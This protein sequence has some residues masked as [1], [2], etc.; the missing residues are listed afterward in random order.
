MAETQ[1]EVEL[2]IPQYLEIL[3]RRRWIIL[4]LASLFFCAAAAYA[5]LLPPVFRATTVL[6]IEKETG[7]AVQNQNIGEWQDDASI[8]TQFQ[9]IVSAT[10]LSRIYDD[11]KLS[12]SK[13]FS[14]GLDSLKNAVKVESVAGTRLC[15]INVDSTDPQLAMK[16]SNALAQNFVDENLN[17]KLSM[18]KDVLDALQMRMRGEDA[19]RVTMSLPSVVNNPLIQGIKGQINTL[20]AQL[21]EQRMKYTNSHPVIISLRSRLAQMQRELDREV[22]NIVQSVKTELSGQLRAN[23]VRIVDLPQLPKTPVRPRKA[24][25]L[26]FGLI[27]G[28][29]LGVLAALFVELLDQTVRTHEHV[30]RRL[31]LP[32]LG[33]IP[34]SRHKKGAHIYA[35]LLSPEVSLT[36]ESFRNLRTMVGFSAPVGGE[37][38]LLVTSTVQE[39]GKSYVATNMAVVLAQLG[40]KVL[41]VEGDLRRPRLHRTLHASTEKGISEFLSGAESDPG[42]LAQKTEVPNLEVVTCGARPPNPAELLNSER[43]GQ[44]LAWAR[45]R[46]TRVIVD[47]P[48]VFPVSD[49]LLWSHHIKPVIFVVRFGRTRVPLILTACARLKINGSRI[50]GGVINGAR[51]GTMTY[52]DG[53]YYEQYYRE[54]EDSEKPNKRHT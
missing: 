3:F 5:F 20:E 24:L 11:L 7:T 51:L 25:A 52:A 30:E 9:L 22:G 13:D 35:P 41:I 36:S 31:G 1:Q 6:I 21:A 14:S 45:G 29:A 15:N 18:S 32:F 37:P 2:N 38:F 33:L 10:A 26:A 39:E 48:P 23:N 54:Y 28:L 50:L 40:Q 17:T 44:F 42:S 47:C 34:Y 49:I 19:E 53:R 16:I 8:N 27:G 4:T 12:N 46:Y 43:L